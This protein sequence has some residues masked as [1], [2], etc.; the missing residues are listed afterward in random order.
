MGRKYVYDESHKSAEGHEW[1]R[2][3]CVTLLLGLCTL[4][5]PS[6]H[7]QM[8]TPLRSNLLAEM[9][10]P[11]CV[12][13]RLFVSSAQT[14]RISTASSIHI[15]VPKDCTMWALK[16]ILPVVNMKVNL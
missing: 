1:L 14:S 13:T 5:M 2:G 11:G 6:S 16:R 9:R 3:T 4:L 12:A 10:S 7:L 15:M 8:K